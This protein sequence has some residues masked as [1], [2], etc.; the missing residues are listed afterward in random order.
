MDLKDTLTIY[1]LQD[2]FH[3]SENSV[4]DPHMGA[5]IRIRSERMPSMIM[6]FNEQF[7]NKDEEEVMICAHKVITK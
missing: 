5:T 2:L 1:D 4:M 6:F 7:Q 3:S